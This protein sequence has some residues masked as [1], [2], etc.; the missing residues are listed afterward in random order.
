MRWIL[1][2]SA[3]TVAALF[4][5]NRKLSR[6]DPPPPPKEITAP[7]RNQTQ[8]IDSESDI[9]TYPQILHEKKIQNFLYTAVYGN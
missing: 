3:E 6:G 2:T 9:P 7:T 8:E 1:K 4:L 5:N